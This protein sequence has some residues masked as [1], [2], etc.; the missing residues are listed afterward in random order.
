MSNKTNYLVTAQYIYPSL[1]VGPY[2]T[3]SQIC[4]VTPKINIYHSD[5]SI[6]RS[7]KIA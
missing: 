6:D 2:F 5:P 3:V 4:R 1:F 7:M